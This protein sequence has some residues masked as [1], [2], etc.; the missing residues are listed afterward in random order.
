MLSLS[1]SAS[2]INGNTASRI[3]G[4]SASSTLERKLGLEHLGRRVP[5]LF[6]RT[7]CSV[8]QL[9]SCRYQGIPRSQQHQVLPDF[10][11]PVLD[12]V[13]RLWVHS[14]YPS[15]LMGIQSVVFAL[16]TLR[17]IHQPRVGH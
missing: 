3:P 13:Q 8:D 4:G 10:P 1:A 15:E 11:T 14:P 5:I 16:A 17:P 12:R 7:S 2:C 6:T 9:R